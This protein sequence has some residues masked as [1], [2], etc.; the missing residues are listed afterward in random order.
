MDTIHNWYYPYQICLGWM[1]LIY[2]R[3]SSSFS[4]D[5]WGYAKIYVLYIYIDSHKILQCGFLGGSLFPSLSYM[6]IYICIWSLCRLLIYMYIYAGWWY[7][8][9]SEKWWSSSV[10]IMKF[11]TEWKVIQNSNVPNHQPVRVYT[12][13][14]IY[15]W[16]NYN[17]SLTWIKAIWGWFLLLTMI[18]R[19]RSQWGRYNLPR[20]MYIYI[21]YPIVIPIINHY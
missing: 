12:Y 14:Y 17:I 11:P 5:Q 19:V 10:G 18:P 1:L 8:Y 15:I 13:I 2:F 6:Y 7:T 3:V 21:Y 16:V 4:G 9:P 20:Y